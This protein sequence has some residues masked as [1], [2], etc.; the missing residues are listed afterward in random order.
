MNRKIYWIE[1]K[2]FEYVIFAMWAIIKQ[3]ICD[4]TRN[5]YKFKGKVVGIEVS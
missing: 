4:E 3:I 5:E 1:L 2:N